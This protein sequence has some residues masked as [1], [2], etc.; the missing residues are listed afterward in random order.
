MRE[1]TMKVKISLLLLTTLTAMPWAFSAHATRTHQPLE[2]VSEFRA[3]QNYKPQTIV[4]RKDAGV[5]ATW[6]RIFGDEVAWMTPYPGYTEPQIVGSDDKEPRTESLWMIMLRAKAEINRPAQQIAIEKFLTLEA[7]QSLDPTVHHQQIQADQL[8]AN[9]VKTAPRSE[10][11]EIDLKNFNWCKAKGVTITK[12]NR[13]RNLDHSLHPTRPWCQDRDRSLCIES[14]YQL[15]NSR[16]LSSAIRFGE[17]AQTI[18]SSVPDP[19]VSTQSEL[20]YFKTFKEFEDYYDMGELNNKD[21]A[22]ALSAITGIHTP[23]ES[24]VQLTT[25]YVNQGIQYSKTLAILYRHPSDPQKS[26]VAT[27]LVTGFKQRTIA[28]FERYGVNLRDF[29]QGLSQGNSETGIT[30]GIPQYS[31]ELMEKILDLL[32]KS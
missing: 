32:E 15:E 23:V 19:G 2:K 12:M 1:Q 28:K 30:R 6:K 17:A 5:F 13:E 27:F 4:Y 24:A 31:L 3:F 16:F 22:K 21:K 10:T 9:Q 26:L 20:R 11:G 14:C 8:I 7:V 18:T 25:F 29:A